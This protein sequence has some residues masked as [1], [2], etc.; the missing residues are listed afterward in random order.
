MP[1][2]VIRKM[3]TDR[4]YRVHKEDLPRLEEIL[5]RCFAEDP[6]YE[7][8]IPDPQL[9]KRLMPELFRLDMEEMYRTCEI[10]A[11]SKELR[12]VIVVSDEAEPCNLLKFYWTEAWAALHTDVCLIREDPSLKTLHNFLRGEDY[13]NSRWTRDLGEDQR[14]HIV[15]LAVDPHSQHH[16]IAQILMDAVIEYAQSHGR[17]LSLETHNARNLEFYRRFG[18]EVYRILV[19]HFS[20]KQYCLIREAQTRMAPAAQPKLVPQ[21]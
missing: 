12:G 9:R 14:I 13:L 15:Y 20:L 18:F 16:G 19:K 6:L 17:M 5:N 3:E 21:G 1:K 11:D 8:L 7:T 4:L 2:G 10:F